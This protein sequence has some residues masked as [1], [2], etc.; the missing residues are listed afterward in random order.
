MAVA[1]SVVSNRLFQGL[2]VL[3]LSAYFFAH[4][5]PALGLLHNWPLPAAKNM[6]NDCA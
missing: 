1:N 2:S 5:Q 4:G 6:R 3:S